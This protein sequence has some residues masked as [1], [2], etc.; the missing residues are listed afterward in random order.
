MN[1]RIWTFSNALSMVRVLL[2]IP[3]VVLLLNDDPAS[4]VYA[5]ALLIIAA[6]TDLFDGML[7]RRMHQ[8][9]DM[10]RIVD[11]L[12]D[13]I[14]VGAVAVVLAT[15][16]KLPLW[17]L[18]LVLMRDAIIFAGGVYVRKTRRIILQSNMVGKWTVTAIALYVLLAVLEW[19][20]VSWLQQG[21]LLMSTVMIIVSFV[22]YFRRFLEVTQVQRT[23]T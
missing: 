6:I 18:A 16:G 21:V 23:G 15:Q 19:K 13:K 9:T 3:I 8:V 12:A 1:Q 2:V 10:G 11:P 17:Y 7:A 4:R 14:A 22:L 5:A 20:E